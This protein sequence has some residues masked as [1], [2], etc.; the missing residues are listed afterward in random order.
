MRLAHRI[1]NA[2]MKK[3]REFN[4]LKYASIKEFLSDLLSGN[5]NLYG[6]LKGWYWDKL[7]NTL[8]YEDE[9]YGSRIFF[10]DDSMLLSSRG[11]ILSVN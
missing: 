9:L 3:V 7:R 10:K 11:N 2:S 8:R 5:P 4:T 6:E 1:E